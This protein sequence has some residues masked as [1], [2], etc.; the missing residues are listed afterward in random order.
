[1]EEVRVHLDKI[2]Q[3]A[4]GNIATDAAEMIRESREERS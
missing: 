3:R 1:M 4:G 2:R